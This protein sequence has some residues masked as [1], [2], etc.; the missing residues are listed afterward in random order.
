MMS[1]SS[2]L[3]AAVA[4]FRFLV[5]LL[6]KGDVTTRFA[7]SVDPITLRAVLFAVTP[8]ILPG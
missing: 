1:S 2:C 5:R 7:A 3:L 8:G 6:R 4:G